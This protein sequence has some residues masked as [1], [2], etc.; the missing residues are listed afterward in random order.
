MMMR[1]ISNPV[2]SV[3]RVVDH[4]AADRKKTVAAFALVAIM[5]IMWFRVL[6]GREPGSAQATPDPQQ[7]TQ[8]QEK[9]QVD[10]RFRELPVIPGRN[11]CIG[12]DFFTVQDW[13]GFPRDSDR[14]TQSTDPEVRVV[15]PD[16]TQEVVA[17]VAQKLKVEAVLW[18]ENPKAFINDQLFQMGDTLNCKDG[19]EFYVFEVVRIEADSV[20]VR[21][22]E[23][24]LTLKLA[25]SNDV[26]N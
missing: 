22:R 6:T 5:A 15:A 17:R 19:T 3:N 1:N 16:P 10:I 12:R 9:P 18:S 14:E 11:D 20:L 13:D 26:S 24:Q 8:D 23:R 21:C 7:Q 4:M 2:R 25:Q